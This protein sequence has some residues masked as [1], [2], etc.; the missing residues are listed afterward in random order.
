MSVAEYSSCNEIVAPVALASLFAGE[1][2]IAVPN[3][4]TAANTEIIKTFMEASVSLATDTSARLAASS[5]TN[6]HG[7]FTLS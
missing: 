2:S 7:P 3:K 5:V 4:A 1:R 6:P